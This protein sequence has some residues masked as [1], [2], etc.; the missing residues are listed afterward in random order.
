M[1]F[2]FF[3]FPV[4]VIFRHFG[5]CGCRVFRFSGIG[6]SVH[7]TIPG[8]LGPHEFLQFWI[9][10]QSVFSGFVDCV[11]PGKMG[12]LG[13]LHPLF[14]VWVLESGFQELGVPAFEVVGDY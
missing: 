4:F 1:I 10:G 2:W 3:G 5:F 7:V 14:S 9:V 11:V 8:I 13:F 12:A 6:E